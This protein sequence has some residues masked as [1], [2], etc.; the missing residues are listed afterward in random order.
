MGQSR[1]AVTLPAERKSLKAS[2]RRRYAVWAAE[3]GE[4]WEWHPR[5]SMS[6]GP[7]DMQMGNPAT[8]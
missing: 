7:E 3:G 5:K 4:V 8:R 2:R 1:E 6:K